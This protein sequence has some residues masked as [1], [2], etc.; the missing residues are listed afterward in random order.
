MKVVLLFLLQALL[1]V[2]EKGEG[3]DPAA[4]LRKHWKPITLSR[5]NTS[6][7][8][9][10]EKILQENGEKFELPDNWEPKPISVKFEGV[11]FWQAVDE[12]CRLDG[13]LL[14]LPERARFFLIANPAKATP[15]A[16]AGP[17]R[18]SIHDITRVREL[19]YPDRT[20]RTELS[21]RVHWIREYRPLLDPWPFPGTVD[22]ARAEDGRGRSLLPQVT[23]DSSF[24][25]SPGGTSDRSS[26]WM[27]RLQPVD[28][29]LNSIA[30]LDLVWKTPFPDEVVDVLFDT[31]TQSEGVSRPVGEFRL[32][33]ESCKRNAKGGSSLESKFVLEADPTN[34]SA[35]VR[36]ELEAVPLARRMLQ[37]VEI[38]GKVKRERQYFSVK[39]DPKNPMRVALSTWVDGSSDPKT[40]MVRVASRMSLLSI[41]LSFKDLPL[42]EAGK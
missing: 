16:Y 41:P 12:V 27:L 34:L 40:L 26:V 38:D 5:D 9:I 10:L 4:P 36:R 6:A 17:M 15:L 2:Q 19:A 20:D 23:V 3:V 24:V 29:D 31:P 21:L 37:Y 39:P 33:L 18:F 42:P 22:V 25:R 28:R 32:T 13:N 8:E 11:T 14:L 1:S 30:R 35:A 7:R